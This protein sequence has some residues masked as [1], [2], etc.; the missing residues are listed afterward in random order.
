MRAWRSL[1]RALSIKSQ[2]DALLY[3][4]FSATIKMSLRVQIGASLELF[5][6][7]REKWFVHSYVFMR[8]LTNQTMS[9]TV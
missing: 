5:S 1:L 6:N 2:V 9:L 3:P 4:I 8:H 7:I